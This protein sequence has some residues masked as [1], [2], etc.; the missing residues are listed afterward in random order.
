MSDKRLNNTIFIMYLVT[1]RYKKA[2]S[3]TTERFLELDAK[4][5]LL[6]FM[7][8][9]PDIFDSMNETEMVE[10]IDRYVANHA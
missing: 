5:G 10:E 1:E 2:H 9:C 4:Y 3:I 6:Q 8:E 7:A